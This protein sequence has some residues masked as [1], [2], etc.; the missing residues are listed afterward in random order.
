MECDGILND[1]VEYLYKGRS[2]CEDC[3]RAAKKAVTGIRLD[4]S[5]ERRALLTF[6]WM[7]VVLF[8]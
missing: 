1:D 5:H 4:M 6:P 2:Y 8:P 7:T 3:Y